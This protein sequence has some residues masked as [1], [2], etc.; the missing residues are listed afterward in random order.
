MIFVEL[1]ELLQSDT[2]L[3]ARVKEAMAALNKPMPTDA[4][5]EGPT[6]DA[7]VEHASAKEPASPP[8]DAERPTDASSADAGA[9]A[10]PAAR[11]PCKWVYH[12]GSY[13]RTSQVPPSPEAVEPAAPPAAREHR[14][15]C[16]GRV[17]LGLL[18]FE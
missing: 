17:F 14:L 13:V 15:A 11:S 9:D 12:R 16:I 8:A 7:D 5:K 10:A 4:P 1:L 2:K 6:R 18:R 3:R